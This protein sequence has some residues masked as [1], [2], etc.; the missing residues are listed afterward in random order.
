MRSLIVVF[1][2]LFSGLTPGWRRQEGAPALDKAYEEARAAALALKEAEAP[3]TRASSRRGAAPAHRPPY[4]LS[5]VPPNSSAGTISSRKTAL[6]MR[7]L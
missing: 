1:A 7:G 2:A 5:A 6:T 3:A 4:P